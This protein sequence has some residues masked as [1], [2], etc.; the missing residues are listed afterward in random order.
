[1]CRGGGREEGCPGLGWSPGCSGL[2]SKPNQ[3]IGHRKD[4]S[5]GEGHIHHRSGD[6]ASQPRCRFQII[7]RL[8][9]AAV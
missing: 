5:F 7:C 3:M 8:A 9:V 4:P 1:M 2:E 6:E